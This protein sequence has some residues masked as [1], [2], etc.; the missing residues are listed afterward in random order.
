MVHVPLCG[1]STFGGN[2]ITDNS[3]FSLK[4][5][6]RVWDHFFF[7]G[8]V[9][10]FKAA[11]YILAQVQDDLLKTKDTMSFCRTLHSKTRGLFDWKHVA[12]VSTTDL[13]RITFQRII[14]PKCPTLPR[15]KSKNWEPRIECHWKMKS[16]QI[17]SKVPLQLLMVI[18]ISQPFE[19]NP[20]RK[21]PHFSIHLQLP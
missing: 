4:T 20:F 3:S 5:T 2:S 13:R 11:I 17:N 18:N 14:I 12:E 9:Y 19:K 6:M 8:S 16:L 1:S 21:E 10:L 15:T 7:E